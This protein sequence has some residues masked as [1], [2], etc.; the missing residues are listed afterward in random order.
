MLILR[1]PPFPLSAVYSG[2]SPSSDFTVLL[3]SSSRNE[4]FATIELSSSNIGKLTIEI[5]ETLQKYDDEYSLEVLDENGDTVIEDNLAVERPYVD[6]STLA[7]TASDIA[8]YTEHESLARAIIDSITGGFYFKKDYLETIGQGTD[9]ISLWDRTYK[10]LKAYENSILVYDSSL[11]Q[12]ALD[13]FNYLITKDKTS[14]IKDPIQD[15][16]E[17]NRSESAPVGTLMANSDS[18]SM[19]DTSDSGVTLGMKFGVLFPSGTDYIFE[20]E[21][22]YKV[23]PI[24]IQDATKMLIEDIACGKLEYFKRS[25]VDYSTDQFKIKIEKSSLSGTGNILVDKILDKYITDVKKP[26]VL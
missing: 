1:K 25:I 10:I 12:P 19:F 16:G 13:G 7:T 11:E 20:V 26:G 3:K 18:I 9:Y 15:A 23:I 22:G 14:I 21:K 8:K 5:P 17:Y 6:P 4:A 2:L 24:D